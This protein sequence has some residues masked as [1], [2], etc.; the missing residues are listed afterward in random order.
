M[1]KGCFV[2]LAGLDIMFHVAALPL[3]N[4]KVKTNDY[5]TNIGGPAANAA[6]THA[7]LGG[8][9]ILISSIGDSLLG[10]SIKEE[11]AS[12]GV[13]IMDVSSG[14][15]GLPS[16]SGIAVNKTSGSRT[17][18]SGQRV[19][20]DGT[21]RPIGEVLEDVDFCLSDCN[22]KD[23]G[24]AVVNKAKDMGVPV[25]LD[26]G[27]WKEGFEKFLA[28]SDYTIA[29]SVCH[30]PDGQSIKD[31]AFDWGSKNVAVTHGGEEIRYF[32]PSEKG[33]INP[34]E[35]TVVDKLAAGDIFHGAFCYF[36]FSK[37]C[38][39][40]E[41]LINADKVATSSVMHKGPRQ[42]IYVYK[43]REGFE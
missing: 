2:G 32:S 4:H 15:E 40:K 24:L 1:A 41:A 43:E 31:K 35:V 10:K 6:I 11:L 7:I 12:Y 17:I 16:I 38:S 18:W 27:N 37:G 34:E 14:E 39:F 3:E 9:S 5:E 26:A 13:R 33:V 22:I 28:V 8:E 25:V 19:M 20:E 29:S 36:M 21:F 23:L 30:P 42:G